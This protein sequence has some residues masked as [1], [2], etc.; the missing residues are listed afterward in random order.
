MVKTLDT[1]KARFRIG[2]KK[3]QESA[4]Q[5]CC[6]K[7]IIDFLDVEKNNKF[8]TLFH[9]QVPKLRIQRS[10]SWYHVWAP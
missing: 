2:K 1:A 8:S 4:G 6:G 10:C 7:A 5:G 3:K 9:C